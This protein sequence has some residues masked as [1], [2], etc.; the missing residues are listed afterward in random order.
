MARPGQAHT[1]PVR[2]PGRG[3]GA[4]RQAKLAQEVAQRGAQPLAVEVGQ[5]GFQRLDDA[6]QIRQGLVG[7][8]VQPGRPARAGPAARY[9]R[10][11]GTFYAGCRYWLSQTAQRAWRPSACS[12]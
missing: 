10:A 5:P 1:S 3:C 9:G 12:S 7:R 8:A 6:P 4:G 11:A 2:T